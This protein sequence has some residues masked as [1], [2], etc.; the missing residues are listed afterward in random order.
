MPILTPKPNEKRTDYVKRVME[1]LQKEG[2]DQEQ[3]AAIAYETWR[4]SKKV[5]KI[6]EEI[7]AGL[8]DFA[9]QL[10]ENTIDTLVRWALEQSYVITMHKNITLVI[11]STGQF[12]SQS[13]SPYL[14]LLKAKMKPV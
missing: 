8:N 3:A 14:A 10:E 1:F 6:S 7:L 5:R 4:K 2:Y 9:D 13:R 11:S 12:I